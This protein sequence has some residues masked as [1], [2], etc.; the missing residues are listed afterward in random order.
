LG[1]K[2]A[3]VHGAKPNIIPNA[4]IGSYWRLIRSTSG[5]GRF[6][7]I[8]FVFKAI[9]RSKSSIFN[10]PHMKMKS[11]QAQKKTMQLTEKNNVIEFNIQGKIHHRPGIVPGPP[12]W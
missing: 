4:V 2:E 6:C 3:T 5:P 11:Y 7:K 10:L 1:F 9:K 12:S 8:N